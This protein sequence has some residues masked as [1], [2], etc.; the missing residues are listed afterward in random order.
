[1]NRQDLLEIKDLTQL[2]LAVTLKAATRVFDA[3]GLSVQEAAALAGV[4]ILTW[5]RIASGETVHLAPEQVLRLGTLIGLYK[6]LNG[7]YG[8]H[9][10]DTW[11]KRPQ[12]KI[13][14]GCETPLEHMISG[15]LPAILRIGQGLEATGG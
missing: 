3:W 1:M 8:T 6:E 13:T 11:V 9:V 5:G 14:C 10:S 15:G 2:E 4:P 7:A 12:P